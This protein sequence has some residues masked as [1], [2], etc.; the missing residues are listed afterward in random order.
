MKSCCIFPQPQGVTHLLKK[1]AFVSI[2]NFLLGPLPKDSDNRPQVTTPPQMNIII[3]LPLA[4]CPANLSCRTRT[5]KPR[6]AGPQIR[7][8]NSDLCTGRCRCWYGTRT[9]RCLRPRPVTRRQTSRPRIHTGS[10]GVILTFDLR[11][12]RCTRPSSP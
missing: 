9:S 5:R 11:Q 8:R 2:L 12:T 10:P 3:I 1:D 6:D 7:S 4:P